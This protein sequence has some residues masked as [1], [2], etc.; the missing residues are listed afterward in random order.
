[1]TL[2]WI[3]WI[4][5]AVLAVTG[6]AGFLRGLVR[7]ALGLAAWIIALLAAR[8]LAPSVAELL[9][10]VI[11]SADGRLVLAFVLVIFA[12]ILLCGLVIRMVH[13]A[14][15]WVGMGLLN[16]ITGTAFGMAKGVALLVLATLLLSL[17]PLVQLQAWQ[18]AALRPTFERL[19]EWTLSHLAAW[20]G[21]L[22]ESSSLRELSFPPAAPTSSVE[23]E[24][25]D[26][27]EATR[28]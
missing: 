25:G 19:Q 7:E 17:T 8:L 22:P 10:G 11:D 13:A 3:D 20:E 16:R 27:D 6:L 28:P 9:T 24:P 23:D 4:F 21:R 1:M 14:V 12:V 15:E 26:A 2:T 5:V 18:E